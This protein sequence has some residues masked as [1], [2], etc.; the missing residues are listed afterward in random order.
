MDNNFTVE[1]DILFYALR[2]AMGRQTFAPTV[3]INNIKDNISKFNQHDI[4]S[5]IREIEEKDYYGADIDKI[6]WIN[7][8]K[9]LKQYL[10]IIHN[11]IANS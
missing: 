1:K 7:F 8:I 11:P 10:G 6:N 9:Y 3:V 2:Y 5:L 4:E